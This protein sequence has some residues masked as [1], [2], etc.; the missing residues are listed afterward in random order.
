MLLEKGG[1]MIKKIVANLFF[2]FIINKFAEG[3]SD[4]D[5]KIAVLETNQGRIGKGSC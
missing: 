4:M 5:N 1:R 3:A 2:M